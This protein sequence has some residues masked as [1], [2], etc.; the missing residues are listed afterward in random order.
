MKSLKAIQSTYRQYIYSILAVGVVAG[1]CFPFSDLIGY[2]TVSLMLLLTV[3]LLAMRYSI[4]PVTLSA[5]LSALI[6]DFFFIPPHFTFTVGNTEDALMLLMYFIIAILNGVLTY[7]LRRYDRVVQKKEVKEGELKLYN[8][9][10]NS[11]SH[12]L[13][14]P[15]ATILA[16]SENLLSEDQHWSKTDQTQMNREIQIAGNRLNR[17]VDN[18]L[19]VSRLESGHVLL[20]WDWCDLNELLNAA[21]TRLNLDV[22]TSQIELSIPEDLPLVRLDFVLME[23]AIYNL[24]HNAV[25]YAGENAVIKVDIAYQQN[26]LQIRISDNGP[27]LKPEDLS[28]IFNKFYRPKGSKA[29]GLGLGLSIVR[30]VIEAHHGHIELKNRPEGGAMAELQIPTGQLTPKQQPIE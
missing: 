28:S 3:S 11:L 26:N 6:W 27:G 16:A 23:Q 30:G 9:L 25:M 2:R 29:G 18:L 19:N 10:F 14:T 21:V 24:L 15:I 12:E 22:K 1:I 17:L 5:L 13:R 4:G 8:T 7:Q 20:K